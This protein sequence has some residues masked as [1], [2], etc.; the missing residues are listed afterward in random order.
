VALAAI[1]MSALRVVSR[2]EDSR[3]IGDPSLFSAFVPF[4]GFFILGYALRDV[5]VRG[6]GRILALAAVTAAL[7]LETVWQVTVGGLDSG[8]RTANWLGTVLP[9][10]YQGWVLGASAVAMFVLV[11]SVAHPESV[12]ARPRAARWSRSVGDLALGVFATH[13]LVLMLLQHVPGHHWPDG[14]KTIP[15]LFALCTAT[16]LGATLLTMAI[17]AIPVLRR[18]V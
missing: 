3:P 8:L 2:L 14:A 15:Q 12:W 16:V 17:K 13:L 6:R 4:I 11:R 7:C 9:V 5:I 1:N 18:A 10:H